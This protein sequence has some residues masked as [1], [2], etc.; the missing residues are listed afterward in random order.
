MK[1]CYG[2]KGFF[3]WFLAFVRR[4]YITQVLP[5]IFCLRLIYSQIA[6]LYQVLSTDIL[7]RRNLFSF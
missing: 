3:S 1:V 6:F 5:I 7:H 2:G 4:L